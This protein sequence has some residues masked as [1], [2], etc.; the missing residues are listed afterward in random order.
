MPVIQPVFGT[1][2]NTLYIYMIT[3]GKSMPVD[4]YVQYKRIINHCWETI[5]ACIYILETKKLL[6]FFFFFFFFFWCVCGYL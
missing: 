3:L 4:N 5:H 1:V 6:D 2:T